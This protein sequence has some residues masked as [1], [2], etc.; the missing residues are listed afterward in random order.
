MA[1]AIRLPYK[2]HDAMQILHA[3]NYTGMETYDVLVTIENKPSIS[4]PE[5]QTIL[6]DLVLREGSTN[7]ANIRCSRNLRFTASA[8]SH[9]AAAQEVRRIC[10][11]L[12]IYNPLVSKISI[13][14]V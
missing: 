14:K 10:D 9:E 7:V 12:R 6:N 5:G 13:Q 8:E 3:S 1:P 11:D 4:D 2:T